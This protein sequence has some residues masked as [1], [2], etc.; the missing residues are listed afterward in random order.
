VTYDRN[1]Q[2]RL[3]TSP[4]SVRKARHFFERVADEVGLSPEHR[5]LGM[6]ALS[7][8]V[9]NAV[10]H[11][12]GPVDVMAHEDDRS[13][14]WEVADRNPQLPLPRA[15]FPNDSSGRGLAIVAAVA[16]TWGYESAPDAAGKLVWFE[17]PMAK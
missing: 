7:E 3:A 14:R 8:L 15:A 12:T 5:D 9:T 6:L 10:V 1:F 11:G 16:E 2:I 4:G 17:L 13:I